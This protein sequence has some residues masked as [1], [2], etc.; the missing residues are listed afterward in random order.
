MTCLVPDY[1][2][3]TILIRRLLEILQSAE[4]RRRLD[5]LG[6]YA[7]ENPGRSGAVLRWTD[8]MCL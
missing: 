6:G 7:L 4:F 8:T 5:R 2:R 1:A 3:D